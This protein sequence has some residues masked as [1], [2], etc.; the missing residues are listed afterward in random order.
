M[1]KIIF[2]L[3]IGLSSC[4]KNCYKF[5]VTTITTSYWNGIGNPT[6][7]RVT[8]CGLTAREAKKANA[9]LNSTSSTGLGKQQ[10]TV[11]TTSTYSIE[12]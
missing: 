1:K 6:T 12:P 3:V 9:L 5:V 8:Q 7:T 11:K 10:V 2:I 4:Q